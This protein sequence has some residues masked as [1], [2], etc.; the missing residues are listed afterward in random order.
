[1]DIRKVAYGRA[2]VSNLGR[3]V[4]MCAR[5]R[6]KS[7]QSFYPPTLEVASVSELSVL[8]LPALGFPTRPI[9]GSLGISSATLP[10]LQSEKVR[11][12]SI[13]RSR[14]GRHVAVV[15]R[16][17]TAVEKYLPRLD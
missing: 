10:G 8:D 9:R 12:G 1:M 15:M 6:G 11:D 13:E 17:S 2:G 14:T 16:S 3:L 4:C 5:P 7:E